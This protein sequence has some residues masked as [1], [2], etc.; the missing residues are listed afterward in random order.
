[1]AT[2]LWQQTPQRATGSA[3]HTQQR[4]P[5]ITNKGQPALENIE[6]QATNHNTTKKL[7]HGHHIKVATLNCKETI[8]LTKRQQITHIMKPITSTYC[9]WK[10]YIHTNNTENHDGYYFNFSI[11]P[12]ESDRQDMRKHQKEKRNKIQPTNKV[13]EKARTRAKNKG[14]E[15]CGVGVVSTSPHI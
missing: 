9:S 10:I 12:K 6:N 15:Q 7:K 14:R 13:K 8:G 3:Q 5:N 2:Q 4:T 1:M 11:S